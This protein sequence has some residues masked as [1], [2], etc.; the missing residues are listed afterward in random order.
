MRTP[1]DAQHSF[2]FHVFVVCLFQIMSEDPEETAAM[3]AVTPS[4]GILMR[5]PSVDAN[6]MRRMSL[7][8]A[9]PLGGPR[10]PH[11]ASSHAAAPATSSSGGS[12]LGGAYDA[13][14]TAASSSVNGHV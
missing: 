12:F 6:T 13:K 2:T 4:P 14:S 3:D 5:T 11:G 7:G 9:T 10:R 8:S 1:R